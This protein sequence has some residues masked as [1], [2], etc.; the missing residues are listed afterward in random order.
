M[1]KWS[2]GRSWSPWVGMGVRTLLLRACRHCNNG[3]GSL[4]SSLTLASWEGIHIWEVAGQF[5]SCAGFM[6]V[7]Q[8]TASPL[9]SPVLVTA[10]W[11]WQEPVQP[12]EWKSLLRD[13][14]FQFCDTVKLIFRAVKLL[15]VGQWCSY[16]KLSWT[17]NSLAREISSW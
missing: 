7:G 3:V 5:L 4:S 9:P 13:H 6:L 11:F 17:Q 14:H 2:L 15:P 16:Q 12:D 1:S 8:P 10:H